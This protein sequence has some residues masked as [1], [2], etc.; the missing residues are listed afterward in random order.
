MENSLIANS[1]KI[2]S[3]IIKTNGKEIDESFGLSSLHVCR[4]LNRVG[5]AILQ[6]DTGDNDSFSF[7]ECDADTFKPGNDIEIEAGYDNEPKRVIFSGMILGMNVRI[8]GGIRP[9]LV[10]EC[11]DS[12]FPA[13]Q[14][15]KNQLFEKVKDSDIIA[16][17]GKQYG[18]S[19]SV[20]P[21][22]IEHES[23]VQYY[24][25]DWDF[26]RSRAEAN[27]LVI[28]VQGKKMIVERPKVS[29]SPVLT[30]TNG[31]NLV[32]FNGT[33]S[34]SEQYS[35]VVA[36]TWR[37][38]SQ[39]AISETASAP[40]VNSQGNIPVKY[41]Q[42]KGGES[43]YCQ[44]DAPISNNELKTW[45]DAMAMRNAMS[46]FQG[47]FSFIGSAEIEPGSVVLLEN[48]GKRFNGS[49][50]VGGV[51]HTIEKG[52]WITRVHMG[53]MP[54]NVT[55]L[56]DVIAPPGAGLLPGIEGLHV[57]KVK[58][59]SNDPEKEF[60][61]R[62]NIPLLGKDI[63]ARLCTLYATNTSGSFFF[64]E[65][66]DEVVIGYFN[67]DPRFPV[68]LGSMYSS[69]QA[70]PYQP[71]SSN[72]LKSIVTRT[73]LKLE[74]DEK[75]KS[76]KLYTP[77]KNS[78]EINDDGKCIRLCDQHKNEIIMNDSG[79]TLN[80]SKDLMMKA[81]GN[82]VLDA[83]MKADIKAK[84]DTSIE[85]LNVKA[86]AKVSISVSGN[87]K[88]ELSASGQTVVKGGMVMI[89]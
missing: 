19:V 38:A 78:I 64:P 12:I 46:R 83:G 20:N 26:I 5:N 31:V 22:Q 29:A 10:V 23:L 87:A 58:E 52:R 35:K 71:E 48:V 84:S 79:I 37:I 89:N 6:F 27:G 13:T 18:L 76:I 59:I 39:T 57:G 21:T 24:C 25:S 66:G 40:S 74:F 53:L 30:V 49:V 70:A 11:R 41:L 75:Q 43:L 50:Y 32:S 54:E 47:D 16:R 55:D 68:I 73:Q 86:A 82:I 36:N 65:K 88:A 51:E 63:W 62:V 3:Y 56:P 45:A 60:R 81:R 34:S 17:L 77:G 72:D 4:I 9:Q 1:D 7:P 85:G 44:T 8:Q 28:C 33:L 61:V 15:R 67:N 2:I 69:K 80:S 14:G 42:D